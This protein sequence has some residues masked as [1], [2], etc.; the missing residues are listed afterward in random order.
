MGDPKKIP[1]V[2]TLRPID[3]DRN[4]KCFSKVFFFLAFMAMVVICTAGMGAGM[5]EDSLRIHVVV[6]VAE[7][8]VGI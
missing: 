8:Y 5:T 2:S 6:A 7:K 1:A 4:N 3:S